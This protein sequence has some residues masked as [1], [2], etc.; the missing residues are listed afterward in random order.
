MNAVIE[1]I[2]IWPESMRGAATSSTRTLDMFRM[3]MMIGL[4]RII[5]RPMRRFSSVSSPLTTA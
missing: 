5:S 4:M 2:S 3:N 1:P